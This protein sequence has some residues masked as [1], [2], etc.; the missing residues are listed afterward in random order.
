MTV[1]SQT[2]WHKSANEW[3]EKIGD[4]KR[5]N[6][7]NVRSR[8]GV[9]GRVLEQGEEDEEDAT[10]GPHVNGLDGTNRKISGISDS[11]ENRIQN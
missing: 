3:P 5:L 11:T 10:I 6:Y 4:Y 2:T 9:N 1:L 8:G 7:L